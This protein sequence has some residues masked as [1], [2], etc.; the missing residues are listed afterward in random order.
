MTNTDSELAEFDLA[1]QS[2]AKDAIGLLEYAYPHI[3]VRIKMLWGM[4]EC[5]QFITKLLLPTRFD[6]EG[7][8]EPTIQSLIAIQELHQRHFPQPHDVWEAA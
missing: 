6:R 8:D 3:A 7:F 5:A 4:P 2:Q 1:T